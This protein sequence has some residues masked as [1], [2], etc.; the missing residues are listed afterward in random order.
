MTYRPFL[1]AFLKPPALPVVADYDNTSLEEPI[2]RCLDDCIEKD[3]AKYHVPNSLKSDLSEA[4]GILEGSRPKV[5]PATQ[6]KI[7]A[8]LRKI[9]PCIDQQR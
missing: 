1:G 3:P 5:S 4:Y 2:A 8:I 9:A 7:D 6:S